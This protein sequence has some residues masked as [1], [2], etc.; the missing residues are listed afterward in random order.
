MGWDG[1][2]CKKLGTRREEAELLLEY[3]N[4]DGYTL[5]TR[6]LKHRLIGNTWYAKVETTREDGSLL[7]WIAV[8]LVRWE[9]GMLMR[10]MMDNSMGPYADDCPVSWLNDVPLA[11]KFDQEWRDR[12]RAKQGRDRQ[13]ARHIRNLEAG[14]SVRFKA[15]YDDADVWIYTGIPWLFRKTPGGNA[16]RLK[17]WRKHLIEIKPHNQEQTNMTTQPTR[18]EAHHA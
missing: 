4:A 11:G 1:N 7:R 9:D 17:N 10:K 18:K 14:D 2:Y 5:P 6:V 3:F 15:R 8:C 12:C 13:L 16:C